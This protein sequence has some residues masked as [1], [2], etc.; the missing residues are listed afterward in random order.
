MR[1]FT[2][3]AACAAMFAV[4]SAAPA[5]EGNTD[6][7]AACFSEL[8]CSTF[9]NHPVAERSVKDSLTNAQRFA[10]GLPPKNPRRHFRPTGVQAARRQEPSGVI[11]RGLVRVARADGTGDLGYLSSHPFSGAQHRYQ[12]ISNA[13]IVS[14]RSTGTSQSQIDI[15]T[16]VCMTYEQMFCMYL[17]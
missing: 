6:V 16:E 14:F 15:D 17:C 5:T 9:I 2:L 7:T 12:D 8:E 13:M 11:T 4:S 1:F 10:R 3:F